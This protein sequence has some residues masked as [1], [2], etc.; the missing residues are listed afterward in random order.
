MLTIWSKRLK[1]ATLEVML[2]LFSWLDFSFYLWKFWPD[3]CTVSLLYSL[4]IWV[5]IATKQY[6]TQRV[7]GN[8]RKIYAKI[9]KFW[10]GFSS[11]L[12]IIKFVKQQNTERLNLD[13]GKTR[14]KSIIFFYW[15]VSVAKCT[16]DNKTWVFL[17]FHSWQLSDFRFKCEHFIDRHTVT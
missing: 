13:L 11:R 5:A 12:H 10:I 16:R 4:T 8:I 1:S 2:I 15:L 17:P 9:N 14:V 6:S 3:H 7:Y